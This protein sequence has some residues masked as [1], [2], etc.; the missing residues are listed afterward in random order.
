MNWNTPAGW[1]HTPPGYSQPQPAYSGSWQQPAWTDH[2]EGFFHHDRFISNT[3]KHPEL[4]PILAA[5]TT[6][7]RVDI[8]FEPA[9]EAAFPSK[10]YYAYRHIHATADQASHVRLISKDFPWSIDIKTPGRPV[11]CDDVWN[12]LYTAL[13]QPLADSEWGV[14]SH[15]SSKAKKV[16]KAAKQ[17]QSEID[18]D[19]GGPKR[20]DWVADSHIFRGLEEDDEFSKRRLAYVD[21]QCDA[22]FVVK[23]GTS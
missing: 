14:L 16:Q 13:Q 12:A 11:T 4:H 18:K 22:T 1:G 7:A 9:S 21:S 10:I 6:L 3:R 20:V 8:R 5:E 15:D 19:K 17:R 2:K 23:L